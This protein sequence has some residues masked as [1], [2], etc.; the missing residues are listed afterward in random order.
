M[1]GI[2]FLIKIERNPAI[3]LFITGGVFL[4]GYHYRLDRI[5]WSLILLAIGFVWAA[6]ALNTA[7]ELLADEISE[8]LRERLGKAKDIAAGGV[9]MAAIIAFIIGILVFFPHF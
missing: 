9:L 6:E 8:D 7:I 2:F 1:R 4:A 3:Y 5:E